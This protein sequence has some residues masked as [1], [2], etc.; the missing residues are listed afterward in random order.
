[1]SFPIAH[2]APSA[3]STS[4]WLPSLAASFSNAIGSWGSDSTLC[5]VGSS[6][7]EGEGGD[8][9]TPVNLEPSAW[10]PVPVTRERPIRD[11]PLWAD[12]PPRPRAENQLG[13]RVGTWV[14][15]KDVLGKVCERLEIWDQNDLINAAA[16]CRRCVGS[17]CTWVG[18]ERS[19]RLKP[20]C[21]AEALLSNK[22]TSQPCWERS[23]HTTQ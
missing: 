19:A 9:D 18:E 8:Q 21:L 17:G 14:R 5:M 23:K 4:A 11:E 22:D 20:N 15:S 6:W 13:S 12:R 2:A 3:W 7:R 1:M 10:G 16:V